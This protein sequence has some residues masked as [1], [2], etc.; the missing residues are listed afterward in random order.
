M[1][2]YPLLSSQQPLLT[3]DCFSQV[4]KLKTWAAPVLIRN[5]KLRSVWTRLFFFTCWDKKES[6]QLSS[7]Q[8]IADPA[9]TIK[10]WSALRLHPAKAFNSFL[11][12]SV[13]NCHR[14]FPLPGRMQPYLSL[15]YRG[16]DETDQ[17]KWILC[18]GEV[19]HTLGGNFISTELA[20]L[21]PQERHSDAPLITKEI[22]HGEVFPFAVGDTQVHMLC[23]PP[24]FSVNA[25][26]THTSESS[27]CM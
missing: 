6:P 13:R 2:L 16:R 10:A 4:G 23:L 1:H 5:D 17:E 9:V 22:K 20:A 7:A 11:Q 27:L 18:A 25:P 15:H 24:T 8:K 12:T 3:F 21:A 19:K 26:S 14:G